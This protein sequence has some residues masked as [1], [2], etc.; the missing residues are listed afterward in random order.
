MVPPTYWQASIWMV[1]LGIIVQLWARAPAV[2]KTMRM[3]EAVRRRYVDI[4][5]FITITIY[6]TANADKT[7]MQM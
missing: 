6:Y 2:A 7:M 5:L 3:A 1:S 4:I